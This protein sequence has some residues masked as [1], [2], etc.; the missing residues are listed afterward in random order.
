VVSGLVC[1]AMARYLAAPL[2]RVRDVSYRLAAGDL[3]ARAGPSV[4]RRRDEIGD[5]VRD[6]DAMAARI[7][8]LVHAQSQLLSDISHRGRHVVSEER[9]PHRHDENRR[10]LL[11]HDA[12]V[13]QDHPAAANVRRVLQ[14]FTKCSRSPRRVGIVKNRQLNG[15][16]PDHLVSTAPVVVGVDLQRDSCKRGHAVAGIPRNSCIGATGITQTSACSALSGH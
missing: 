16:A 1:F 8:A 7:E 10:N 13:T 15:R 5:L 6:F 11:I 3:H 14:T 4:G 9:D 2:R 12:T